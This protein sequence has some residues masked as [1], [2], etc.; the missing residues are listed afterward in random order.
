MTS[1][2]GGKVGNMRAIFEARQ[3][4][5][6]SPPSRGRSPAG[7]DIHSIRS[8]SSRPVSKIRTSFV[9]VEKSGTMGPIL[10]LRMVSDVQDRPELDVDLQQSVTRSTSNAG[11]E[12]IAEENE[13]GSKYVAGRQ[14]E[15]SKPK[16]G[17][18][19][20]AVPA[21]ASDTKDTSSTSASG[22]AKEKKA[23]KHVPTGIKTQV[24]SE[25]SKT[26]GI[27]TKKQPVT[28]KDVS[29]KG[30]AESQKPTTLRTKVSP[31]SPQTNNVKVKTPTNSSGDPGS[32]PKVRVRRE[33]ASKPE[34]RVSTPRTSLASNGPKE[35]R[36][37]RA[38]T[39]S[40]TRPVRL[41]AAAMASTASSAAK[42]NASEN[43][44]SQSSSKPRVSSDGDFLARMMRPT[45]ASASKTH[46]K[47][48]STSGSQKA[49]ASKPKKT[50]DVSE[51]RVSESTTKLTPMASQKKVTRQSGSL[52]K[53]STS[54]LGK[55]EATVEDK[56][57]I[58]DAAESGTGESS[59]IKETPD[60]I[61]V[62]TLNKSADTIESEKPSQETK[63]TDLDLEENVLSVETNAA[64]KDSVQ[65]IPG[66]AIPVASHL[67]SN[68]DDGLA[69]PIING[70]STEAP[71]ADTEAD[72]EN[73][74][75]HKD[76][77]ISHPAEGLGR[78]EP[79]SA[80]IAPE[81]STISLEPH[82][83]ASVEDMMDKLAGV[84][85]EQPTSGV[86]N[87][88]EPTKPES[89]VTK[90]KEE[91]LISLP[92]ESAEPLPPSE[93]TPISEKPA[94]DLTTS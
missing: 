50:S 49:K 24:K 64:V 40:P 83:D 37:T 60:M 2:T 57:S 48:T 56:P 93:T 33:P 78:R 42:S 44:S 14:G 63:S 86:T 30:K 58:D 71:K 39:K 46:E 66:S 79:Q 21:S 20:K 54:D 75:T 80:V 87:V 70:Y 8:G 4:L 69:H 23:I 55:A 18:N 36:P 25:S 31:R 6:S 38:R 32:A 17:L 41:P 89:P 34:S 76:H 92:T 45:A 88:S 72:Q 13:L 91:E 82:N 84:S 16:Q 43:S 68:H 59:E 73:A 3:E 85:I 12:S 27:L 52:K 29:G 11:R 74:N 90:P 65:P 26:N 51:R 62:T 7:S 22:V 28:P 15:D 61:T 19:E 9:A 94:E 47:L 35:D 10:G 5:S 53:E 67:S 1:S 81:R 77:D